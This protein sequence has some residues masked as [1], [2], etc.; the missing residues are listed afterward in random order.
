MERTRA[1]AT[2]RHE[3][4][5]EH[6]GNKGNNSKSEILSLDGLEFN[7]IKLPLNFGFSLFI[8]VLP[9]DFWV[10]SLAKRIP[11]LD[12]HNLDVIIQGPR[13]GLIA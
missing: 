13:F 5:K 7:E 8:D 3:K 6:G 2:G 9:V 4:W 11:L 12:Q 10:L 1:E